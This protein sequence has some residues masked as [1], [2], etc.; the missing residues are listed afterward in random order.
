MTDRKESMEQTFARWQRDADAQE[1]PN[2]GVDLGERIDAGMARE[3][4]NAGPQK[5]SDV[6][7]DIIGDANQTWPV[8]GFYTIFD[9]KL[10]AHIDP[11]HFINDAVAIR[12]WR[13]RLLQGHRFAQSP[14][15]YLL[16]FQGEW[17]QGSGAQ[18]PVENPR[19]VGSLEGILNH[20]PEPN[21][22]Q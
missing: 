13:E 21:A 17:D 7:D 11:L 15:D 8:F 19:V 5:I 12:D 4:Q 16:C 9:T 10:G 18:I 3:L 6:L 20:E 2:Q 22:S 14:A 1:L